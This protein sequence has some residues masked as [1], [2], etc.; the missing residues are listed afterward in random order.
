MGWFLLLIF[1][2]VDYVAC[3]F[4]GLTVL[5]WMPDVVSFT[6]LGAEC[7]FNPVNPLE[8]C[9]GTVKLLESA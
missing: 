5:D 1:L 2:I 6:W 4:I 9:S 7:F 3:D 8:L